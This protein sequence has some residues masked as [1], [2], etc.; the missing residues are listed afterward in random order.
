MHVY[1]YLLHR[2]DSSI[3]IGK[4]TRHHEFNYDEI[5]FRLVLGNVY[6]EKNYHVPVLE[7][8]IILLVLPGTFY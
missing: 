4:V 6:P 2:G 8:H 3:G 1:I 5:G 7:V